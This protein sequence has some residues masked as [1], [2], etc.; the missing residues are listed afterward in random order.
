M[1]DLTYTWYLK[2]IETKPFVTMGASDL[3]RTET[4]ALR[5][6][7]S[8]ADWSIAFPLPLLEE[9]LCFETLLGFPQLFDSFSGLSSIPST[10]FARW[11][12]LESSRRDWGDLD[13]ILSSDD[14]S[15]DG[16]PKSMNCLGTISGASCRLVSLS[17]LSIVAWWKQEFKTLTKVA[18][19]LTIVSNDD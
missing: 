5:M 4:R 18:R 6:V 3:A 8:A 17:L 2:A 19:S 13:V 9:A 10:L 16:S 11:R 12:E 7:A 15:A 1:L 14:T